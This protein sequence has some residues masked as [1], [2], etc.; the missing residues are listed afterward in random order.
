MIL[1]SK[2]ESSIEEGSVPIK[3]ILAYLD[4]IVRKKAITS[5]EYPDIITNINNLKN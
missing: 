5:K 2:L 3:D 4:E 1:I